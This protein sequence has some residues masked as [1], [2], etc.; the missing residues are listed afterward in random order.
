[1]DSTFDAGCGNTPGGTITY[2]FTLVRF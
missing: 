2:P 1:V